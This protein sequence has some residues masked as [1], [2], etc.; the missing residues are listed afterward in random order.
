MC[1]HTSYKVTVLLMW[2]LCFMWLSSCHIFIMVLVLVQPLKFAYLPSP[3]YLPS[4]LRGRM[5]KLKAID[6]TT[7]SPSVYSFQFN[8]DRNCLS[9]A[10]EFYFV[11]P[12]HCFFF[13]CFL[14]LPRL[15]QLFFFL[16]VLINTSATGACSCGRNFGLIVYAWKK[17][18]LKGTVMTHNKVNL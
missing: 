17:T 14:P 10:P 12:D 1:V 3:P 11:C 7:S 2:L 8:S 5:G 4:T 6:N 16:V 13:L 18:V 9:D 15:F